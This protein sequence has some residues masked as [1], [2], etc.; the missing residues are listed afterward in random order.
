MSLSNETKTQPLDQAELP[1]WK[2]HKEVHAAKVERVESEGDGG[3]ILYLRT[4]SGDQ[5][6]VRVD[7]GYVRK[8]EPKADGY[9]V[10]YEDGYQSWSPSAAFEGG[11]TLSDR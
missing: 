10:E 7:A 2:S 1:K 4:P 9:F 5:C 8:H 11:Y 6:S 3:A